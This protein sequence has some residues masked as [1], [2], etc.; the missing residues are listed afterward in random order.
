M[1]LQL[2]RGSERVAL[3]SILD[4]NFGEFTF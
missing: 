1:D 4:M 3:C 2:A